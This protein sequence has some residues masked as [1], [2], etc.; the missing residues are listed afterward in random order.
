MTTDN[1]TTLN[2]CDSNS[3]WGGDDGTPSSVTTAGLYYENGN[4]LS[5]Q[6]T[7]ADEH[8]YY[9]DGTGWDLSDA[10][11]FLIVK[12]NQQDSQANGGMKYV[13]GDGT[14]R[15]GFEVG[16][17]DNPGVAL[18]NLFYGLS[19]DVTN[20]SA[21]TG[22][23]FAGVLAN[24]TVA[25]IT[26]VG[27]G[28]NH[29][30]K[31]QG[32]VDNIYLDRLSYIA[33]DSPVLTINGGT[34]GTPETW[35]DVQGDDETNG[36]GVC[37]NPFAS[38]FQ[39]NCSFEVGVSTAAT[40]S[41]FSM[42]GEQ[43][44]LFGQAYAATH[45]FWS[46]L[47]STGTNSLTITN[48]QIIS[49][50]GLTGVACNLQWNNS[51]FNILQ[52]ENTLFVDCGTID[53]PPQS[54]SNRY[55]N[56]STFS[57]CGQINFNSID[58]VGL[59]IIGSQD[60][61]GAVYWDE[62][63]VEENQD[64]LTFVS[65]GTGHAIEINPTGAGPFVYN[66]DGYVFDGF[67]GQSGTDTNRVF[68]INPV[69]TS[70]DVTI[71]LTGSTALNV[72][73]GGAGFSYR[74]VGGYTGTVTINSTVSITVTVVDSDNNPIEGA[75]VRVELTSGGTL[76]ANGS[77]NASGVFSASYNFGGNVGVTTKV[78]LKGYKFFRTAGTITSAGLD[79]GA[80]LQDDVIVDLP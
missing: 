49:V 45:F 20:R 24:L 65:D 16:G 10:T 2:A 14:D 1:R 8:T 71:N 12:V 38:Q 41:Y 55:V 18:A 32:A 11:V 25:A 7:N 33:N 37:G 46:L 44:Y 69:T 31:A 50:A 4:S 9:T 68:F 57:N 63:T 21:F 19:L 27:Y 26:Q 67:A 61:N 30:A 6:H 78:R 60:A 58:A 70:A 17:S 59:T 75:R 43:L 34:S 23:V 48:A 15:I 56:G 28:S 79:V 76:V 80:T 73:G 3:G 29:L 5:M 64:D 40:D 36:W 77:T 72:Q 39:I 53:F 51:S 66:I 54:A 13:L 35:A 22:H 74:T 47:A 42:D 52:I 62:S